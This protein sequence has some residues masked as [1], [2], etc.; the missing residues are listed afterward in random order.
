MQQGCRTTL[1]VITLLGS[2]Y[3]PTGA[4][5]GESVNP[6]IP[7]PATSEALA[8]FVPSN[9]VN[10]FDSLGLPPLRFRGSTA[11]GM[12]RLKTTLATFP[13]AQIVS[14]TAHYLETIFTTTIGFQDAVEFIVDERAQRIDFR[15]RSKFGL[16]DFGKNRSRMRDFAASF[17]KAQSSGT[18]ADRN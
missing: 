14:S 3:L 10:S 17:E 2:T 5:A 15:S 9:C 1:V 8:C 6:G 7:S 4:L 12:A 16:F 13:E 11:D 18:P